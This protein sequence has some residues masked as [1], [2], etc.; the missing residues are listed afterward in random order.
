[1][2]V[3]TCELKFYASNLSNAYLHTYVCS[4]QAGE[5]GHGCSCFVCNVELKI[6]LTDATWLFSEN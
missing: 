5:V 6:A 2:Y 3:C 4:I 1:M